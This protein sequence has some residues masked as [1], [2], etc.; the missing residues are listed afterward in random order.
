MHGIRSPPSL[1]EVNTLM[2]K[3]LFNASFDESKTLSPNLFSKNR[4]FYY[5]LGISDS[6][7]LSR[8][9]FLVIPWFFLGGIS[10]GLGIGFPETVG[11]T[12]GDL[13]W[14]VYGG[15]YFIFLRPL[16][17]VILLIIGITIFLNFFPKKNYMVQRMFGILNLLFLIIL[18]DF[19]L[20]PMLLG[21]TLGAT[22]WLGFTLICVYGLSFFFSCMASRINGIKQELYKKSIDEQSSYISKIWAFLKKIWL[23]PFAL[24]LINIF[25]VR[26]GMWGSFT[27]WSFVWMLAG[28]IYFGILTLLSVGPMKMFVSSFYFAK[29]AEQYRVLWRVTDE[30][31]YGKRKAKRI[32]KKKLK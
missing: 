11:M 28:P 7:K 32:A 24:L 3:T 29:Y 5:D 18:L 12:K 16:I 23:V 21:A 20:M 25:T 10:Y 19:S 15:Q 14:I 2:D 4:P 8:R 22:G 6:E 17:L 9:L 27:L 13:K 30:Q 31:W 1:E 26:L